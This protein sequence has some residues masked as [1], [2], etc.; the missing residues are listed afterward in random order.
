MFNTG[1]PT[2]VQERRLP[3]W[4]QE[5][6]L[7]NVDVGMRVTQ[8]LMFSEGLPTVVCTWEGYPR[9]CAH[10][11]VTQVLLTVLRRVTQVLLTVLR[12]VNP[13]LKDCSERLTRA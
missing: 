11:R 13:G 1:L 8:R 7:P 10:G 4:V 6:R 3:T 5:R 2:W 12:R 9:W